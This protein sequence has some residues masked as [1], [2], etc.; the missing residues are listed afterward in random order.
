MPDKA[1]S[2]A[3]LFWLAVG[4]FAAGAFAAWLA[5]RQLALA[6]KAGSGATLIALTESFRQ[7]WRAFLHEADNEK[8][9]YAFGDLANTLEVACA[10][11][12]DKV[13]FGHSSELLENYLVH[14]FRLLEKNEA[15]C[16]RLQA[17][18][19]TPKTF[20]NIVAFL[21]AHRGIGIASP[22]A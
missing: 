17:M 6:R 1:I 21:K 10:I 8:R 7:C 11:F 16:D 2:D 13:F 12:R 22:P 4:A 19:Q 18:L 15:S 9:D 20:E 5:N 3:I 14:L